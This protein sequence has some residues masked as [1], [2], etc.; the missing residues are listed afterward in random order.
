[1]RNL[2]IALPAMSH[3]HSD[4]RW[5]VLTVERPWESR[6]LRLL[7]EGPGKYEVVSPKIYVWWWGRRQ[8]RDAIEPMLPGYLLIRLDL[9]TTYLK[10]ILDETSRYITGI[11]RDRK[12]G[13]PIALPEDAAEK[14]F[15]HMDCTDLVNPHEVRK[16]PPKAPMRMY[17]VGEQVRITEGPFM[18]FKASFKQRAGDRVVAFLS[19]LGG[20]VE[21]I[22]PEIHVEKIEQRHTTS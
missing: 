5:Y 4:K 10:G 12:T 17:E 3:I 22:I 6:V 2:A 20:E 15:K 18:G 7:R 14:L 19:A 16:A 8:F 1:M 13:E 9:E 21:A 11:L